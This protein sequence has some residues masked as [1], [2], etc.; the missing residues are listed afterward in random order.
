LNSFVVYICITG[1]FLSSIIF[2]FNRGYKSAN[3]FLA[4][5][6]FSTAIYILC[7]YTLFLSHSIVWTV[8]F[9]APVPSFFLLIGP[10]SYLYVRSILTDNATLKK[11]DYLH[12]FIF[13]LIF[14]GAIPFVFTS[15]QYKIEVATNVQNNQ[16]NLAK[17]RINKILPHAINQ[18][19]RPPHIIMYMILQWRLVYKAFYKK[20]RIQ[21]N[22]KQT[23]LI[24]RWMLLY[25]SIF[26]LI[27]ITGT[28]I[29]INNLLNI[30]KTNFELN[31][32]VLFL[33]CTIGFVLLNVSL[34]LFPNITYGLPVSPVHFP[35]Q[36]Y[37]IKS[38]ELIKLIETPQSPAF[39]VAQ[40]EEDDVQKDITDTNPLMQLFC[41]DYIAEIKNLIEKCIK[42]GCY[43]QADC[44]LSTFSTTVDVPA[45]HLTYYFNDIVK[46]KFT[47][48]KN[49]LRIA[50]AMNLMNSASMD[51]LT[52]EA[53]AEQ[54]GFTSRSTFIRAFKNK[55]KLTP[56]DYIKHIKLIAD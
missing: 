5:F 7:I 19:I 16:W 46:I 21:S 12:F 13:I 49:D 24:K 47:D 40:A 28:L 8:Y 26:S 15:W 31:T 55:T 50:Y 18:A 48:W 33:L 10:S 34:L 29:M 52:L 53:I 45:H 37:H 51:T 25:C 20:N 43:L 44:S 23:L 56:S 35:P 1:F 9:L 17:Y 27:S 54:S 32:S 42:E 3:K 14:L 11:T 30:E 4:L 41:D 38:D 36:P 6:L 22:P 2:L 39:L